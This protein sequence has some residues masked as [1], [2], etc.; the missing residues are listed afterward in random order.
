M[1][2]KNSKTYRKVASFWP[3]LFWGIFAL[4]LCFVAF[5]SFHLPLFHL[6]LPEFSCCSLFAVYLLAFGSAVWCTSCTCFAFCWMHFLAVC[7][8]FC[9]LIVAFCWAAFAM[10][11]PLMIIVCVVLP[12]FCPSM[13]P[14]VVPLVF[15]W[16]VACSITVASL[17]YSLCWKKLTLLISGLGMMGFPCTSTW[18]MWTRLDWSFCWCCFTTS[19]F[20]QVVTELVC[21]P[22]YKWQKSAWTGR[23]HRSRF[24]WSPGFR[25]KRYKKTHTH[26]HWCLTCVV[27][28][29][30][31]ASKL[32]RVRKHTHQQLGK[33]HWRNKN[34]GRRGKLEKPHKINH[35]RKARNWQN[36]AIPNPICFQFN[37]LY[38]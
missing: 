36:E 9:C 18:N 8:A 34:F 33:L 11:L 15:C 2:T 26:T 38:K 16:A 27:S 12:F 37:Q 20:C 4:C 23:I 6:V 25:K 17:P 7:V 30:S 32:A 22:S 19:W 35:V 24:G 21:Q 31:W 1:Q 29:A 14:L 28:L 3:W 10:I 13:N 5:G